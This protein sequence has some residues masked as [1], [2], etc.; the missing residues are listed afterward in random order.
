[1]VTATKGAP[2]FKRLAKDVMRGR[3]QVIL[4]TSTCL[5]MGVMVGIYYLTTQ[6]IKWMFTWPVL[7]NCL[8]TFAITV[9]LTVF[10]AFPLLTGFYIIVVRS[11]TGERPSLST[12]LTGYH[13]AVYWKAVRL[14][15]LKGYV[16]MMLINSIMAL[17]PT[18]IL[19]LRYSLAPFIIL[20]DR[21]SD[22]SVRQAMKR[23]SRIMK[24]NKRKLLKVLMSFWLY[25]ALGFVT[26]G[27]TLLYA[28]PYITVTMFEFYLHVAVNEE[29]EFE[30]IDTG[31]A[32]E[33]PRSVSQPLIPSS[34][35]VRTVRQRMS[36][37]KSVALLRAY[38]LSPL[39]SV[40]VTSP[41]DPSTRDLDRGGERERERDMDRVAEA[42]HRASREARSDT[43]LSDCLPVSE[44][45]PVSVSVSEAVSGTGSVSDPQTP[46]R[47]GSGEFVLAPSDAATGSTSDM[48]VCGIG[49]EG[50]EEGAV[51]SG[52]DDMADSSI[53]VTSVSDSVDS[54]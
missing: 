28:I 23:S 53:S 33:E 16:V 44:C 35:M 8:L 37:R 54:L 27:L 50:G 11:H 4:L 36:T 15:V 18:C 51:P 52:I 6:L 43:L 45:L 32:S 13:P 17:I 42:A 7:L 10:V 1:M 34:S 38:V 26:C 25:I 29:T 14:Y 20:D 46:E 49:G 39:L 47:R 5:L 31:K 30:P 19:L 21:H 2:E 48:G 22:L 41:T 3:T 24:G 12:L 40:S 9:A